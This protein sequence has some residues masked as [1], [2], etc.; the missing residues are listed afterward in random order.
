MLAK[1]GEIMKF[2]SP[3][4][5]KLVRVLALALAGNTCMYCATMMHNA[6][7]I[8]CLLELLEL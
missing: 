4:S 5:H 1:P 2:Q 3:I 7:K 8:L 6:R